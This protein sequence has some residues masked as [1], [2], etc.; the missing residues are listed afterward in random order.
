MKCFITQQNIYSMV[1]GFQ[2]EVIT[3]ACAKSLLSKILE[4]AYQNKWVYFVIKKCRDNIIWFDKK[5]F[6]LPRL[7]PIIYKMFNNF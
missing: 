4:S 2:L 6:T 3:I 5:K 1:V 7:E